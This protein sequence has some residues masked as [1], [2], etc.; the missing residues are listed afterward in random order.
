MFLNLPV[1]LFILICINLR[2]CQLCG[3][4]VAAD[5]DWR[6]GFEEAVN[7]FE[8]A[9]RGLW[10]EKVGDRDEGEADAGLGVRWGS[11]VRK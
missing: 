2:S 6:V 3:Q 4:F 5:D 7:V 8:R 1:D 10:V 9:I 11:F